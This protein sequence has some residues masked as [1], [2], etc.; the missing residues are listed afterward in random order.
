MTSQQSV[1]LSLMEV[2]F[3][4]GTSH[5]S[6][7]FFN[8]EEDVCVDVCPVPKLVEDNDADEKLELRH[9]ACAVYGPP[10]SLP[11]T[12][13][14]ATYAKTAAEQMVVSD[15]SIKI[16]IQVAAETI[17]VGEHGDSVM[18]VCNIIVPFNKL[19]IH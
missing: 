13:K 10:G 11:D 17:A 14:V 16:A 19:T 4:S 1:T 7:C 12:H 9:Y 3:A 15:G 18:Y 2:F 6:A 8:P 5:P